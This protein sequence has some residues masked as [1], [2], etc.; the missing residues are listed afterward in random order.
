MIGL[1]W[2]MMYNSIVEKYVDTKNEMK[3]INNTNNIIIVNK[4]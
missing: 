2:V 1:G 4:I 3:K